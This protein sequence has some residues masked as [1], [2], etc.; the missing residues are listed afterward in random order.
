MLNRILFKQIDNSALIVFRVFFGLLIIF[1]SFG[2]ILTG[3][4]KRVLVEPEFT[5]SFISFDWLQPLPGIG[6]YIYFAIMGVFG[7]GI[8]LGY[9]YRFSIIGFTVMWTFVYLMQKSSYNNHYYLLVFLS[10]FMAIMPANRYYSID[11]KQNPSIVKY[12][13]PQWCSLLFIVQMGIVYTYASVAKWYPDW[14]DTTAIE[15]FMKG[16]KDYVLI[17]DFLQTKWLH[18]VLA[19]SGILFDLL[20]VPLLLYKPTRK[21]AFVASVF[22]HLFNSIVFQ[23]GIFPYMSLALC[24]F[25]FEPKTIRNIF[26]KQKPLYN[27]QDVIIP[28]TSKL[29]IT[30]FV[31]YFTIHILLPLRH[32]VIKDDV[33]WTE[34]GHR[35]SWRMMLRVKSGYANYKV[36]NKETGQTIPVKLSDFL[37]R[38]QI[39]IAS[40]KP[41]VIWQFSQYLKSKFK[42][43]GQDVEVYVDCFIKVNGR[44]FQQLINPEIDLASVK[45]DAFKHSDWILPSKQD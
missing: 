6:M 7:F 22:F 26:L 25:F 8:M 14:I 5:F 15:L 4:V 40:T 31:I 16:K 13:M 24:M 18:Y 42:E 28:N 17:G 30:V 43:E 37:T 9:K 45:W 39:N 11:A 41:D 36:V 2:A 3:W 44:P 12:S 35:L 1:E 21:L 34:E 27:K 32:W 33:L 29:G 23:I 19:Y 38:K 20:V 10:L